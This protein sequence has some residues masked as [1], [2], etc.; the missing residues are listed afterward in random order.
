MRADFANVLFALDFLKEEYV[1][2]EKIEKRL[3]EEAEKI[4]AKNILEPKEIEFL[5]VFLNRIEEIEKSEIE[6]K[7]KEEADKM[8]NEHILNIIKKGV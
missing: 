7:K 2:K 3:G 8:C 1:L 4:L 6:K 5:F